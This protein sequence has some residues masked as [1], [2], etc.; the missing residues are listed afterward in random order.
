[1]I[2]AI[3]CVVR[4]CLTRFMDKV[5]YIAQIVDISLLSRC[6]TLHAS[7]LKYSEIQVL[8]SYIQHIFTIYMIVLL[9]IVETQ[10]YVSAIVR[11]HNSKFQA[12]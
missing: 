11:R 8:L 7:V 4:P 6:F 1:M 12:N 3:C 10:M 2:A 9:H 5:S